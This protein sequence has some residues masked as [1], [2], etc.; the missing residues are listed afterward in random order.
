MPPIWSG[1]RFRHRSTRGW[2][3]AHIATV[4][5]F[6]GNLH[7]AYTDIPSMS[8]VTPTV[9]RGRLAIQTIVTYPEDDLL[10]SPPIST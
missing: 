1:R 9:R 4:S 10:S 6:A 5:D 2:V 7:V 8:C 3:G